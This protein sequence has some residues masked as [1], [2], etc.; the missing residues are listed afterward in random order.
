MCGI[1]ALISPSADIDLAV[2]HGIRDTLLHRGPDIGL[3]WIHPSRRVALAHRRL[4][5]IDVSHEADQ[6]MVSADGNLRLIFNGEIYNYRELRSELVAAGASFR[7]R[8]DTE[9]LLEG[10]AAWGDSLLD[11]ING[12]FAF[13]IWDERQRQ[14]FVARDRF[15]EKPLFVGRGVDGVLL[16]ASEMK[17]I[18]AHPLVRV[19]ASAEATNRYGRATW[20]ED[21]E[22]TFFDGIQRFPPAHAAVYGDDGQQLRKWRYWTPDYEHVDEGL[23]A[24]DAIDRF[25]ELLDASTR[26]RL[27]AD[28]AVGS[29]LSGG[30]DSSTIVGLV[31]AQRE[32][33]SFTQ[34]AFSATFEDDPTISEGPQIDEMVGH[35]RVRSFRVMP[36]AAGLMAESQKLHFHQEE[37]FLSASI[38]L[39]WCVARL[40][41][42]HD[43]TVL[44]DGQGADELLAGYQ[45]WFRFHQ[46]DL[47]D[48]RQF[49]AAFSETVRF[50]RRLQQ[51][52]RSYQDS[53]RR[54]DQRAAFSLLQLT[55]AAVRRPEVWHRADREGL[56]RPKRGMR[57]RRL[58]GETLQYNGLPTLLRYA[59]RNSMAFSRE[60][61]LPFLDYNLVDFC[62]RL[63]DDLLM[64]EG[65]QKW[66]LR[67]A[68]TRV[69]PPSIS[70]RADKVG[71]A[72]PLDLWL[73][74]AL[75][76]WAQERLYSSRLT[77][78]EGYD[79]PVLEKLWREHEHGHANNSW[80]IWRWVSLAEWFALL[81][82]GAW[83]KSVMHT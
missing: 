1:V 7:T 82:S 3:T 67:K 71:Y 38:Y 43:T 25:A 74:G 75:K 80:A 4:S 48:R 22:L 10:F 68:A 51:A 37:P 58:A 15:G 19:S 16:I 30:L 60:V 83:K 31:A 42:E 24:P 40:A 59:D 18:L 2:A 62:L 13:A 36:T 27:N 70:W 28:V 14:L 11:R 50:N 72:A 20:Y 63:P 61:R 65:W 53:R 5:I 39:Q 35:A 49:G 73:R 54:F 57:L 46:L 26:A 29:S 79:R 12:M 69:V 81:D 9:V 32:R 77:T 55:A 45:A 21:D 33:S 8:S 44:L 47:L 64:R 41:K 78:V 52:A 66:I 34:N 6:P 76:T 56:A 23:S 17:A